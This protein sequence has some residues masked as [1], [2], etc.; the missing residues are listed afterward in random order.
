M[1]S[2][3]LTRRTAVKKIAAG[4]FAA[5]VGMP[6]WA[7]SEKPINFV[8]GFTAGG[9]TD[10]IARLLA[11]HMSKSLGRT[12]V[13]NNMV[14]ASGNIATQY[15]CNAK[16]DGSTFLCSSMTQIVV[17]PNTFEKLAFDPIDGLTH[18]CMT[19]QTDFVVSVNSTVPAKTAGELVAYTKSHLGTV[20]F[21]TAGPGTVIHVMVELF[22]QR[23]GADI[24]SVHYKGSA[25]MVTDIIS[26]TVQ[27]CVD[28]IQTVEQY[29]RQGKIRMLCVASNRRN[30]L[31][32]D[33]PTAAE[34][35]IKDFGTTTN[36]FGLHGPA[37]MPVALREQVYAAARAAANQ[38]DVKERLTALG[39]EQMTQMHDDFPGLIKSQAN[40]F[41]EV[42]RRGNIRA[43]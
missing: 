25:Q 4:G 18:I 7:Q 17:S 28:G 36:W 35:G 19:A 32:P 15:V 22:K 2:S 38:P 27:G 33:V 6:T 11:Q 12:I 34:A 16:P 14:G 30:P 8:V 40:L 24:L 21:G 31:I 5:A 23:S 26:N 3:K 1:N 39:L 13:V 37:G 20:N 41:G 9:G 43:A 10:V 29:A 42:A